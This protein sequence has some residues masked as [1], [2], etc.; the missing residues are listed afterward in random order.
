MIYYYFLAG[1]WL[2]FGWFLAGFCL[3]FDLDFDLGFDL[4]EASPPPRE[5][6]FPG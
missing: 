4:E 2:V 1:F 3:A 6:R 5:K